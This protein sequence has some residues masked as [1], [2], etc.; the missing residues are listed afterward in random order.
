MSSLKQKAVSGVF[1]NFV[2]QAFLMLFRTLINIL[3]A[4]Q[5]FPSDYGLIAVVLIF[6]QIS[7][8][9]V[10]GGMRDALIRKPELS[11]DDLSTVFLFNLASSF[12]LYAVFYLVAPF[13]AEFYDLPAFVLVSRVLGL[14]III[15]AISMVQ[16]ALTTRKI[17]FKFLAKV[18]ITATFIGGVVGMF[19]AYNGFGVWS[20]VIQSLI[21]AAIISLVFWINT[22]WTPKWHFSVLAFKENFSFGY[23]LVL[24]SLI[25]TVFS[26]LY[27]LVIGKV[28]SPE[29]LGYYSQ[30][31]RLGEMPSQ[32]FYTLFQRTSYPILASVQNE[33]ERFNAIYLK[34]IGVLSFISFPVALL[35]I[36][37]G[38]YLIMLLLTDKWI[39]AV[40]F[41]YIMCFSGMLFPI[42][43]ISAYAILAKGR[44][45]LAL[46]FEFLYKALMVILIILTYQFDVLIMV[47]G[48]ALLII[49]Q[50]IIN[51]WVTGRVIGLKI[52]DQLNAAAGAFV[53]SLLTFVITYLI[54]YFISQPVVKISLQ[55]V[56]YAS[57]YLSLAYLFKSRELSAMKEIITEFVSRKK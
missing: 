3:I 48:Q 4:R 55:I 42:T 11:S 13:I 5:L 30:G 6:L 24:S 17:D 29:S 40:P 50:F 9:L 10:N 33:D 41:F 20:L 35:M 2:E 8:V 51:Y 57:I 31:K 56:I 22:S 39:N 54:T 47:S 1:W 27:Q 7:E 21:K 25:N 32:I 52:K 12:L 18:N 14:V 34:L 45:D 46:K 15:N 38:H 23:K 19:A 36:L 44:S 37:T 16:N 28:Y 53:L 26:N 49:F 43:G